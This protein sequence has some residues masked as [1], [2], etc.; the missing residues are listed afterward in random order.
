MIVNLTRDNLE[1]ICK[2]LNEY[3]ENELPVAA[4]IQF[5]FILEPPS[6]HHLLQIRH[7]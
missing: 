6:I 5:R 2:D 4:L 1:E 7:N 3:F